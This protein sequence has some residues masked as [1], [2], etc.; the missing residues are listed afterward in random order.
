MA[1]NEEGVINFHVANRAATHLGRK[2]YSTTPPALAE[3]IANSYDA[4]ATEARVTIDRSIDHIIIADNGT[5]MSLSALNKKYALVGREKVEEPA[6]EGFTRRSPM[7]QKGIGKLASFSLGDR[8]EVY[9]KTAADAQWRHFAVEYADFIRGDSEYPVECELLDLPQE[10]EQ[11]SGFDHGFITIIR[12]LR[13]GVNSQTLDSLMTQLSRRFYI[14]SGTG[15]FALYINDQLVDLSLNAYYGSMDYATYVGFTEEDVRDLLKADGDAIKLREYDPKTIK[16]SAIRK[17]LESLVG[18]KGLKGWVGTVRQPKQLKE[19][20]NNANIVVYINGKIADEDVLKNHASSM[21][22]NQYVVG[23]FFA[24]YLSSDAEDP[25]TSSRQGLDNADGE[26][27][28]LISVI[29]SIRSTVINAWDS[30]R[31][32][33]AVRR[34]PA[35]ATDDE[36]YQGWL[37]GLGKSQRR[38]HNRLVKALTVKMDEGEQDESETRALLNSFIDVVEN[39]AIYQLADELSTE[40]DRTHDELLVAMAQLLNR[41]AASE[42][43]KQAGIVSQ[44]L[45]AIKTLRTLMDNP[46]TVEKMFEDHLAKNPW[47][48]NPYWNQTPKT[49]EAVQVVTQEFNR[50]YIDKKDADYKRTF[51]DICIYVA[52]EDYPIIVELKRNANTAYSHVTYSKIHDQITD[53]R[54]AIIQKLGSAERTVIEEEDIPAYFIGSE[55]MGPAG[56]GFAIELSASEIKLLKQSNIELLTYEDLII[57]AQRAYHDHIEVM[58]QQGGVPHFEV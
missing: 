6:P 15:G 33:E 57:H 44:R 29:R 31:E 54:R 16:E 22:A 4:Y 24:D 47:L 11:F 42:S 2:L 13:R 19:H 17:S 41:I 46:A 39:D 7:G 40:S 53:Y 26:V 23:E 36:R 20:G 48:I 35:W 30:R 34:L 56:H 43:I 49:Q 21:I 9:T 27:R 5:G 18:E 1:V 50:L 58:E 28:E 52:D 55:K 37:A 38:L 12:G 32:A 3:L 25:I 51:I 45:Q 14:K 8:Y 10:L